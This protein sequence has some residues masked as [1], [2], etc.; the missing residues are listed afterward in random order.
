MIKYCKIL[1][2]TDDEGA[3]NFLIRLKYIAIVADTG[4]PI[5]TTPH[6]TSLVFCETKVPIQ[7]RGEHTPLSITR[8]GI[9]MYPNLFYTAILVVLI[10][11]QNMFKMF[12]YISGLENITF[13]KG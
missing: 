11:P 8:K 13:V 5:L 9:F 3:I 10:P 6:S 1:E 4:S 2:V 12:P 7:D